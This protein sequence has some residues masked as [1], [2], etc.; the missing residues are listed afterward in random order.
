MKKY[1]RLIAIIMITIMS[2]AL[3]T[4]CGEPKEVYLTTSNIYD[5][6]NIEFVETSYDGYRDVDYQLVVSGNEG[7][8]YSGVE[9][10]FDL[11]SAN[12]S[13]W[14]S[15]NNE[16]LSVAQDGNTV[17]DYDMVAYIPLDGVMDYPSY[18]FEL[19][20]VTGMVLVD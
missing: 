1:T 18:T 16:V 10:T 4:A 8:I 14:A 17:V 2:M 7:M 20:S 11:K 6:L 9:I 13:D 12:T 5:Y 15:K 3:M 19:T